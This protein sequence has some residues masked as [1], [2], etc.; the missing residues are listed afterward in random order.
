MDETFAKQLKSKLSPDKFESLG[1][2]RQVLHLNDGGDR[3]EHITD[4]QSPHYNQ[5]VHES[6][7]KLVTLDVTLFAH[8]YDLRFNTSSESTIQPVPPGMVASVRSSWKM[9]RHKHRTSYR[10]KAAASITKRSGV[11]KVDYTEVLV[12]PYAGHGFSTNN[13]GVSQGQK[14]YEIEFELEKGFRDQWLSPSTRANDAKLQDMTKLATMQLLELID[15]FVPAESETENAIPLWE[16]PRSDRRYY[17]LDNNVS[18]LNSYLKEPTGTSGKVEFLGSMPINMFRNSLN[19]VMNSDYY[20]AEKSDGV[21]YLLYIFQKDFERYSPLSG[22]NKVKTL[23]EGQN[24][25]VFMDRACNTFT[26]PYAEIVANAFPSNT[27]LDGEIVYNSKM[28]KSIFLIFDILLYN[29]EP[30]IQHSFKVRY[31]RIKGDVYAAY[32]AHLASLV[33]NANGQMIS[34]LAFPLSSNPAGVFDQNNSLHAFRG[35]S[36]MIVSVKHFYPKKDITDLIRHFHYDQGERYYIDRENPLIHH[37]TDGIIFQPNTPYVFSKYYDLL[38]WK[39]SDLRSIDVKLIAVKGQ[40]SAAANSSNG[41]AHTPWNTPTLFN[42]LHELSNKD[43]YLLCTGPDGSYINIS[44]R[45]D[46]NVGLGEF[47]TARLLAEI[48]DQILSRTNM[49]SLGTGSGNRPS[50]AGNN[51]YSII[52]EVIYD[53]NIGKWFYSKIRADKTE[54]NYI[55]SVLGVF[56]EQAEAITIEELEYNLLSAINGFDIDYEGRLNKMKGQLLAWQRNSRK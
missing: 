40:G 53:V 39:W 33:S 36:L 48:E 25:C 54:P 14:E 50:N 4:P 1:Q 42:Q 52:A 20:I 6:K 9:E 22:A 24:V 16:I 7:L 38:K 18:S 13:E 28:K 47:D 46:Y 26:F 45:G 44:K 51:T 55:D 41:S 49:S 43:L 15:L 11:W 2:T 5:I 3:Y 23:G 19:I 35:S 31:D 17:E 37:K 34:P 10:M 12:K 56:I 27:I 30:L 21:R 32:Q 8:D 29:G